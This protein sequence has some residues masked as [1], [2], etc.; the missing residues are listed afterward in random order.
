[1]LIKKTN[2]LV[3]LHH[4]NTKISVNNNIA[5]IK[6]EQFYFN[7]MS[8][9][10]EAEYMFP[11]HAAAVFGRLQ[12]KYKDKVIC[13]RIEERQIALQKFDDAVAAG[14]SAIMS[15]PLT[16]DP[17]ITVVNLGNIPPMSEIVVECTF[18]QTMSVE[19]LSWCLYVPS[20]IMPRY[21]GKLSSFSHEG[22]MQTD[23]ESYQ[24][25]LDNISETVKPYYQ[26]LDYS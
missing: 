14:K 11:C 4:V 21:V 18:Y 13:T 19:D 10:L 23:S 26:S 2:H 24:S 22:D 12:M 17:D 8:E 15:S 6:Y 3:P 20:K 9:L 5:E 25:L 7:P 16:S 1:M